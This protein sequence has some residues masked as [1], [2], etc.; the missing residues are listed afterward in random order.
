MAQKDRE[1]LALTIEMDRNV[2][3]SA[4]EL[5]KRGASPTAVNNLAR[6]LVNEYASA[7]TRINSVV[8]LVEV[9]SDNGDPVF[10]ALI[11]R[12]DSQ[13][14]DLVVVMSAYS[15]SKNNIQ[16]LLNTSDILYVDTNKKESMTG[17]NSSGYNCRQM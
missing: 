7:Q 11:L 14:N 13:I 1:E 3:T 8:M 15:R 12:P 5:L 10:V 2:D 9:I 16:N 17:Y 4:E 6:T